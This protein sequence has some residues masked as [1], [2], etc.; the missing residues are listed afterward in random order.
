MMVV[1]LV[2]SLG[3]IA[4]MISIKFF[5]DSQDQFAAADVMA[6]GFRARQ[7]AMGGFQ[8]GLT[9]LKKIPEEFLY[10]SGIAL[11][12]PDIVLSPDCKPK[13]FISYRIYPE[14]GR[15]NLNNLV[16]SF[17]DQPNNQY[18]G[19]FQRFFKQYNINPDFINGIVDWIDENDTVD[20][21]G[22]EAPYY[23]ALNPPRKI[24]NYRM[25]SLSEICSIK[26]IEYKMIYESRAPDKWLENQ[27]ALSFQT[28]EEKNLIKPEDW[29]PANN[30]TA[31]VPFGERIE[32]KI[33]I[34]AARYHVLM[35]LSESMTREAVM[36][37]YKLRKQKGWYLKDIGELRNL[38]EFQKQTPLQVTLYEELAGTGGQV[39]GIIKTEGEIYRI[40]GV[41]S[42]TPPPDN[43]GGPSAGAVVRRIMGLYD[44]NNNRLIY[45]SED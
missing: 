10:K 31:F 8:A 7:Q 17:D 42:I 34:N 21:N 29:I 6:K 37:L 19:I 38:P 27:K 28:E 5:S 22:A 14:D 26:G 2:I 30:L 43:N 36:A 4:Q 32:D 35:S 11:N 13:C 41:G 16:H 1:L 33:N 24:K 3:S 39:S 40:I 12:P 25:F 15:L 9:A 20:G 18:K 45:Y 23:A 44:K